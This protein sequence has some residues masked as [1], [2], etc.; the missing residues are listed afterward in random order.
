[1]KKIDKKIIILSSLI[2]V[3]LLVI[4]II[5]SFKS[6]TLKTNK[7][8]LN[9]HLAIY[10]KGDGQSTYTAQSSIPTG[11]YI[12]NTSKTFCENGGTVS[13]YDSTAG[14]VLFTTLGSDVCSL[15]FDYET[16]ADVIINVATPE[17]IN[18]LYTKSFSNCSNM[19][20]SSSNIYWDY[21]LNGIR[22]K[23]ITNINAI[24]N[25]DFTQ[26]SNP[27][28][29]STVAST[30]GT[31]GN[32]TITESTHGHRYQGNNPDN[33]VWFNDEMWRIIG[34]V[35][36]CLTS[37]CTSTEN[38]VKI[39]RNSSIGALVYKANTATDSTWTDSTMQKLL[40][41]CY[42]GKVSDTDSTCASYCYS[43]YSSSQKP[44]A[45]CDY[46][47]IGI[48]ESDY[49]GSM[50]ESVYWNVGEPS[51]SGY[52]N[53]DDQYTKE[54]ASYTSSTSKIGLM[55]AS[56]WGYAIE[57]FTGVLGSAGSPDDY[58]DK[59]WLFSNG[60]E[61]T[62]SAYSSSHLLRVNF[63]GYLVSQYSSYGCA[64]RPVLYLKSNVY[65]VS[66]SGSEADPYI[67]GM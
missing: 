12:L 50:I 13:N 48:D 26:I 15:Y 46:T 55:Y 24:S 64:A 19:D 31:S 10:V 57:E 66:G 65:V 49:Y 3:L 35:P 56:D 1:M 36:V 37:G 27:T 20:G 40:N 30:T 54:I 16:P 43:Y 9:K 2:L 29:L 45:K 39:I 38:R 32:G 21:K 60:H 51:S 28:L 44:V 6:N 17:Y 18:A 11:Y 14:T 62:M 63:S 7:S 67:I 47:N 33:Y 59:N 34:Y 5:Y 4:R 42:L 53:A 25:L 52:V 8:N 22:L 41:T 23:N 58:M 61:W